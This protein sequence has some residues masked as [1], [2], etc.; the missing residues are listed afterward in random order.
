MSNRSRNGSRLLVL[1]GFLVLTVVSG[2]SDA[3]DRNPTPTV[4]PQPTDPPSSA[5][6]APLCD[7][8]EFILPDSSG[9]RI[10]S[11]EARQRRAARSAEQHDWLS[12][13]LDLAQNAFGYAEPIP[14]RLT[15]T[16]E[17][18]HPVVFL[19]PRS[20]S[21][22]G[23]PQAELLVSLRALSG[24]SNWEYTMLPWEWP[25]VTGEMF[26]VLP[27]GGSCAIDLN[28]VWD[29]TL[30][31]LREPFG[32]GDYE[33]AVTLIGSFVGPETESSMYYDVGAWVGATQPSNMV[34]LTILPPEE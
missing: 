32:P 19:R 5:P 21:L 26:S 27:P 16:N 24:E 25:P 33:M 2:C 9:E 10:T 18:D 23:D 20:L 30:E 6:P 11:E 17:T 28:L 13:H 12:L 3:V 8:S 14:F 1:S 22:S 31:F 15:V 4:E 34:E 29:G 7:S